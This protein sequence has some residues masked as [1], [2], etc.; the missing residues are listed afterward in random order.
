MTI[1]QRQL[2]ITKINTRQGHLKFYMQK[3]IQVL[4]MVTSQ[5][6]NSGRLK[7]LTSPDITMRFYWMEI[8]PRWISTSSIYEPTMRLE[9][10]KQTQGTLPYEGKSSRLVSRSRLCFSGLLV[11]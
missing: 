7:E 8:F 9:A 11:W 6:W 3:V 5:S 1:I 10:S 2:S 4:F